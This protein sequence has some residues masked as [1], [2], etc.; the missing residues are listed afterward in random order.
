MCAG[1][2]PREVGIDAL[3]VRS[4]RAARIDGAKVSRESR[5]YR[6]LIRHIGGSISAQFRACMPELLLK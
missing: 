1:I 6:L 2:L 5:S 3:V 4:G